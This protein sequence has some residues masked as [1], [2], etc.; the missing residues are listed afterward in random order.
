MIDPTVLFAPITITALFIIA[1][2]IA[3]SGED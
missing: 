3:T 2:I 1:L